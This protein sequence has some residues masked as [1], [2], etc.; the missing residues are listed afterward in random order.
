MVASM[1][2]NDKTKD[3]SEIWEKAQEALSLFINLSHMEG[4]AEANFLIGMIHKKTAKRMKMG[5]LKLKHQPKSEF[6]TN[7]KTDFDPRLNKTSSD[8]IQFKDEEKNYLNV[9]KRMFAEMGND[10]G[11]ARVSLAI[12][13][14]HMDSGI[15][16]ISKM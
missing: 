10:Y 1:Y 6:V 8:L 4:R 14:R 5:T 12:A 7:K 2:L 3:Y 9:S 15:D 11:F 13:I 16:A